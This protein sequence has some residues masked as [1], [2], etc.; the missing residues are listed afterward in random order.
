MKQF[1]GEYR[2]IVPQIPRRFPPSLQQPSPA[3]PDSPDPRPVEDRTYGRIYREGAGRFGR[4]ARARVQ[5][6]NT[7]AEK[8]RD[9]T[10][11][12]HG[13]GYRMVAWANRED[14][15]S[16]ELTPDGAEIVM[17]TIMP[18]DWV[19]YVL[20]KSKDEISKILS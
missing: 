18:S 8:M 10:I 9:V 14:P 1:E 2:K 15:T 6:L 17:Y 12:K 11:S 20:E 5:E 7:Y 13:E 3:S 16:E 4:G 19:E